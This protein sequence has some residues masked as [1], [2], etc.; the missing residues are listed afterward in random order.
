MR[1]A[2]EIER[3]HQVKIRHRIATE[4]FIFKLI[5][6]SFFPSFFGGCLLRRL[7]S[8]QKPPQPN[9]ITF[10]PLLLIGKLSLLLF[11]SWYCWYW[12]P[13]A[14]PSLSSSCLPH[15][16]GNSC[17]PHSWGNSCLPHSWGNIPAYLTAEVIS[18]M[19]REMGTLRHVK[20]FSCRR[21]M[22]AIYICH[23]KSL[24]DLWRSMAAFIQFH[25]QLCHH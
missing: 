24:V 15:S 10:L 20:K 12:K 23:V 14:P 7:S 5:L 4:N 16:W 3:E 18:E 9:M 22:G 1:V 11:S 6:V 25:R 19:P 13:G 21:W 2:L 17:L 8:G